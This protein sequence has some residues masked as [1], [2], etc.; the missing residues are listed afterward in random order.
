MARILIG[1]DVE[2]RGPWKKAFSRNPVSTALFLEAAKKLHEELSLPCTFFICGATLEENLPIFR[3]LVGHPLIELAQHTYSHILLKTIV[4]EKEGTTDLHLG[5]SLEQIK[6]EVNRTQEIFRQ[7]LGMECRGLTG[8][9]G[10]Y[11]GLKDRPDILE[12]LA[13]AG[14]KF[15][16]TDA[17]NEKDYQPVPFEN[18]PYFYALQGFPD[19]LEFPVQGWQDTYLRENCGWD[20]IVG[21]IREIKK[22]VD[23]IARGDL[24]WDYCQHDWTSIVNDPQMSIIRELA[25]Y[26]QER[27]VKFDQYSSVY[28]E[29]ISKRDGDTSE[30]LNA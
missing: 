20:N 23:Y 18:Q 8:P 5:A 19:L 10:Y 13:E 2:I 4:I 25:V 27:G 17:R 3:A 30:R 9:W 12:I 7:E 6:E 1:Y 28:E 15:L 24:I 29:F 11:R 22:G 21:F 14:I 16:R 26:A